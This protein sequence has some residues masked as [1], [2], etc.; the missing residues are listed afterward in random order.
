MQ[1]FATTAGVIRRSGDMFELV[2]ESADS[3]AAA[4]MG[5]SLD[6]LLEAPA[7]RPLALGL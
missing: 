1:L 7:L 4:L 3:L 6:A 2:D 5:G